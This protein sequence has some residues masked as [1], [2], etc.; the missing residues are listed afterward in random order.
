M[1]TD[2]KTSD[3]PR[4]APWSVMIGL[5]LTALTALVS[6]I[7]LTRVMSVTASYHSAF[8]ILSIV[9]L[10]MAA[11]AVRAFLDMQR[12]D[13]PVTV[14]ACVAAAY[15]SSIAAC[16]AVVC[17]I[18]V[19]ARDWGQILSPFQ[20]LLAVV[21]LFVWFFYN[22]Y[23]IVIILSNYA[24]D[25]ARL[26]WIDLAGGALGCLLAPALLN[27]FAALNVILL[28]ASGMA[29]AGSLLALT[30]G[31]SKARRGGL[32]LTLALF[33]VWG[34][35]TV[36]PEL[37]R[38]RYA[39]GQDQS[40]VL[41]ERW[42]A[43]ARVSVTTEIPGTSQALEFNQSR[44]GVRMTSEESEGLR[45]LWQSG[46][47]M[48]PKFNGPTLPALW[49]QLDAD[50]GT[51]I[52]QGGVAALQDKGR[53]DFLTW[54]VTA[55]AYAWRNALGERIDNT[56]II[57]GGGGRDVLTALESGVGKVD[58]IELNPA[59][60]EAVQQ[61]FG[62]YSGRIYSHPRVRLTIGE[63]RNELGRSL[64]RYD[65]IQMSMID[66]W[67]SSMAGSMVM[68]ENSLYTREAFD[69]YF[70]RL[71]EG[72]VLSVSRWY[73]SERYGE[74]A[75]VLTL[76]ATTLNRYS[77]ERPEDHV[78]IITSSG[79]LN[80]SVAT[81]FLKR[82]PFT[83]PQLDGLRQLCEDRGYQLLWP[84]FDSASAA[85]FDIIRLLRLDRQALAGSRYD[86]SPPTDDRPFFF[87]I[88]RSLRSWLDAARTG[89]FNRGS[90]ASFVLGATL[91]LLCYACFYFVIKPLRAGR[92][93]PPGSFISFLPPLLYFGGIGLGFILIELALIQRY[94]LLLG[95][96]SYAIS[97]VLFALLLFGGCGSYLTMRTSETRLD[98]TTRLALVM[99]LAGTLLTALAAPSLLWRVAAWPWTLRLCV[100]VTLIAPL[101]LFMGMIFPLGV[102]RLT[103]TGRQELV[104]WM[105]GINGVCGVTASVLGMLLAMNLSYTAVLLAG[106][107][108]YSLTLLSLSLPGRIVA[109]GD[110]L[111]AL[112]RK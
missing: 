53:L 48:S 3:V 47:G 9:M 23:V 18:V 52:L 57:G 25:V 65:L 7:A 35:S 10:G 19:V 45:Q 89:D 97:V 93:A 26:Y 60:V 85:P 61:T 103:A 70:S 28:C 20:L 80:T 69:L 112:K 40:Q 32:L 101:A 4:R 78:A 37:L 68:T 49:L 71:K 110:D 51:P 84:N 21:I 96:P 31:G 74:A 99:V 16:L 42:N 82:S 109:Q 46:W 30:H 11:S 13:H 75:R 73:D 98:A 54:D 111:S 1:T 107:A 14:I 87:N 92:S 64:T 102:W 43:L 34:V 100:A 5:M 41:W 27:R 94:I 95:H 12:K 39:K 67:A 58:V 2:T 38:L 72:G 88:D 62:D 59:V 86:L 24:I 6:Q 63:A 91:L 66:T 81:L 44:R 77:I 36:R 50:A 104:P 83:D 108:A 90:R 105:W 29:V 15:R 79:F 55:A 76:M 106:A 17:F 22:G 56:F 33:S 8:F